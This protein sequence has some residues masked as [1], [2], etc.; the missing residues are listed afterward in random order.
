MFLRLLLNILIAEFTSYLFTTFPDGI[1]YENSWFSIHLLPL[2]C[3]QLENYNFHGLL[4]YVHLH[5]DVSLRFPVQFIWLSSRHVNT[6]RLTQVIR[7]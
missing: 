7:N 1:W 6:M 2:F 3:V 4:F 5:V